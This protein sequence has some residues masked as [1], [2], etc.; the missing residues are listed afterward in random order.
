MRMCLQTRRDGRHASLQLGVAKQR[1]LNGKNIDSLPPSSIHTYKHS[2]TI[3]LF[4]ICI[5]CCHSF[6]KF[7]IVAAVVVVVI[8]HTYIYCSLRAA[9]C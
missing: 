3:R 8:V 4:V 1:S 6:V 2:Y 7:V 5:V 9:S